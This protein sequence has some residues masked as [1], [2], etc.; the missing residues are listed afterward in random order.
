[1]S[2]VQPL[3]AVQSAVSKKPTTAWSVTRGVVVATDE[4]NIEYVLVAVAPVGSTAM[5]LNVS[6]PVVVHICAWV[7]AVP[8]MILVD[9]ASMTPSLF[10]SKRYVKGFPVGSIEMTENMDEVRVVPVVGPEMR[11]AEG[12]W[13]VEEVAVCVYLKTT[14]VG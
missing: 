10:Q 14:F 7:V 13:E 1:M 12:V 3:N 2:A 8:D 4:I 6:L 9:V 5:T 11:G